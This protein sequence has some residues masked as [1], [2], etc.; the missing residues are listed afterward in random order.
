MKLQGCRAWV[1]AHEACSAGAGYVAKP[2]VVPWSRPAS[3]P[4]PKPTVVSWPKSDVKCFMLSCLLFCNCFVILSCFHW[5]IFVMCLASHWFFYVMW[6]FMLGIY[7]SSCFP[8]LGLV[9]FV[10]CKSLLVSCLCLCFRHAQPC[11]CG[12]KGLKHVD[13]FAW[14]LLFSFVM[15][16]LHF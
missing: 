11:F 6:Y 2:A 10:R 1:T 13:G 15:L 3:A 8:V 12:L 16:V 4:W 14:R 7:T 9:L 5:F